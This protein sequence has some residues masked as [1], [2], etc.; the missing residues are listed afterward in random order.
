MAGRARRA[1]ARQGQL[2]RKRKKSQR[3]PSGIPTAAVVDDEAAIESAAD[4]AADTT[5][6]AVADQENGVA[7]V[8][9]VAA[10][11][12]APARANRP[13][14]APRTATAGRSSRPDAVPQGPGR[15]RG[16]RPAAYNY[17]G[18]ELRRISMLSVS[19]IAVLVVLGIVL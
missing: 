13:T 10:P 9:A 5:S 7:S 2:N 3:G 15:I 14:T 12:P 16:E 6:E 4:S 18:A 11:T 19:V 8:E 17:A 1:A